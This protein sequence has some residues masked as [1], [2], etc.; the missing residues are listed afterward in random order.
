MNIC[1]EQFTI[2]LIN[3]FIW[4]SML[5]KQVILPPS[6]NS[7]NKKNFFLL[8]LICK[9]RILF[10][11]EQVELQIILC[12]VKAIALLLYSKSTKLY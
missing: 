7:L 6:Q 12:Q 1:L 3:N 4:T 8:S 9:P 10:S 5:L 11:F 2:M